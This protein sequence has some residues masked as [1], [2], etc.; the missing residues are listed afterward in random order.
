MIKLKVKVTNWGQRSKYVSATFQKSIKANLIKL[1]RKI[2]HRERICNAKTS[3]PTVKVK[4]TE[5][6]GQM[7]S[8]QL[9]K[10]H[11][12]KCKLHAKGNRMR[13]YVCI[14]FNILFPK[15]KVTVTVQRSDHVSD[16]TQ[17]CWIRISHKG[18]TWLNGTIFFTSVRISRQG[19]GHHQGSYIRL[20]CIRTCNQL[21]RISANYNREH[22]T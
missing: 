3:V 14:K 16:L 18:K 15:V 8:S 10:H 13:W 19:Q 12:S 17:N 2:K 5:I 22:K 4:V 11:C 9:L 20:F 1:H 6:N 7:V 21:Q